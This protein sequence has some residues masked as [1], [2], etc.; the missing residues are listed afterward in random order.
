M[1]GPHLHVTMPF[2]GKGWHTQGHSIKPQQEQTTQEKEV[3]ELGK[4]AHSED[5]AVHQRQLCEQGASVK[6]YNI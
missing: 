4:A 2:C 3:D 6:T 5:G 1:A